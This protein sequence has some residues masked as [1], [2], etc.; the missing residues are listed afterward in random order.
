MGKTSRILLFSKHPQKE[1]GF[2]TF[3]ACHWN[4]RE[5][6]LQNPL[7]NGFSLRNL[8]I[9]RCFSTRAVSHSVKVHAN[10]DGMGIEYTKAIFVFDFASICFPV[11]A[12]LSYG[13]R[14]PLRERLVHFS[15]RVPTSF[16]NASI[17]SFQRP[18]RVLQIPLA[19]GRFCCFRLT[20]SELH[21]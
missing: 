21:G 4:I 16:R 9:G 14:D 7:Q 18:L 10:G 20:Y 15:R 2:C 17:F 3:C 1:A 11:K 13:A 19:L 6:T 12:H 5:I 8:G